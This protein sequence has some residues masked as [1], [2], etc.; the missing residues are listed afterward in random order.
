MT[1]A[2][3]HQAI[4]RHKRYPSLARRQGREGIATVLFHLHPDGALDRLELAA[5][6]GFDLLDRAALQ[7][8]ADVGPFA[9]AERYLTRETRFRVDVEFR[10]F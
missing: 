1:T 2:A 3:L 9:P 4:D 10:L 6:S 8:V 7:A 5:S